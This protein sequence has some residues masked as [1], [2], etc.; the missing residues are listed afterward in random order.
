MGRAGG[1]GELLVRVVVL[2]Q[3]ICAQRDNTRQD[4][5]GSRAPEGMNSTGSEERGG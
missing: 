1:E 3:Q 4:Q 2:V 5:I